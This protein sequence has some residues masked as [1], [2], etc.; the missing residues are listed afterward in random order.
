MDEVRDFLVSSML[1]K[2][3]F[4]RASLIQNAKYF[5]LAAMLLGRQSGKFWYEDALSKSP[6]L[7]F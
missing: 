3:G 4:D 2:L 6:V 5:V 1:R 7:L